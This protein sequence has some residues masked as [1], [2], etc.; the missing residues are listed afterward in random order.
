MSLLQHVLLVWFGAALVMTAAW[1][2]SWKRRNA[3]WV[4]VFWAGLM[5]AAALYAGSFSDGAALNRWLVAMMGGLWGARLSLHLMHRV[6]GEPEDGRY[7]TLREHWSGDQRRFFLFF[8]AQALIVALFSVPLLVAAANPESGLRTVTALA[9]VVW[10][11]AVGGEALADRQLARFRAV[12]ANRGRTCR[13]GLW[14][15]SRHPNYF[16]E[17][18]HWFAYALLAV[19]APQAWLALLGPVLM[20]AFLYRFT[21]IP[22]AEQQ[23]LRSRGEDYRR[24]QREVS[25]FIPRPP[26]SSP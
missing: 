17:W 23:A 7:R 6:L 20:L 3:G 26:R 18:L 12:P 9:I 8:Q 5:A 16:F 4:D 21:G 19:G 13:A 24:Y 22:W 10:L 15:W 14:G 25:P 2:L 11:V 1:A